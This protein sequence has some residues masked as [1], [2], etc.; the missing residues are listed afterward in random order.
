MTNNYL[1]PFILLLTVLIFNVSSFAQNYPI[2]ND[3][4]PNDKRLY[5]E[6][7]ESKDKELSI[8]SFNIRNLGARSRSIKD[9]PNFINL[10]DEADVVIFQEV[11]LGLITK[12]P[13]TAQQRIYIKSVIS[14]IQVN[15]GSDWIVKSAVGATGVGHGRETSVLAYRQNP[16]GYSL[17][18]KWVGFTELDKSRGLAEW[19]LKLEKGDVIKN[20][21][22]GSVHLTPQDPARGIEM[23]KAADWLLA[24]G[25]QHAIL[26][27]DMN[28]GYQR[29]SGVENYLGEK[30][31]SKLDTEGKLFHLFKNFSYLGKGNKT[32]LPPLSEW[33]Q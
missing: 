18:A 9:Y 11:G 25:Q 8:A 12:D 6:I 23:T 3:I 13:M 19:E 1:N 2:K 17:S 33:L 24:K 22:I 5:M 16:G 29:T 26:L 20:I 32:D 14:L 30:Y 21:S 7:P 28:W 27:G 4:Q 15:L 31:V 10:V